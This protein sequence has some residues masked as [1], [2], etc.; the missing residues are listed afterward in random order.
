LPDRRR[1]RR[2]H[3]ARCARVVVFAGWIVLS[4]A[5]AL[6]AQESP[7][8]SPFTAPPARAS[9][10]WIGAG[11][12]LGVLDLPKAAVGVELL[13]QI[14]SD[15]LWPIEVGAVYWFDNEAELT[16]SEL[17]L[18]LHPFLLAPYPADGSRIHVSA[19]ELSAALCPFERRIGSDALQLCAGAQ[20]GLL[21]AEGEGFVAPVSKRQLTVDLEGFARYHFQLGARV[22][23]SY[24]AGLF[25]ALFRERFG[26]RDR[27]GQFR[28]LFR[29]A[30]VGARLDLALTYRL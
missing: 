21:W 3:A 26:Y 25:V 7:A 23:L 13:A 16:L 15:S 30:P 27:Y 4:M 1:G 5:T 12:A 11:A 28:E 6:A 8:A 20:V 22:G 17:D 14:R 9:T 2:L 19:A 10:S 29:R 18:E 24:S